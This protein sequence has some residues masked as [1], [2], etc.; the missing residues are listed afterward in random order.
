MSTS[1]GKKDF[2]K[3]G[4]LA[5]VLVDELDRRHGINPSH[6]RI[7]LE[8]ASKSKL[9]EL[10]R[11]EIEDMAVKTKLHSWSFYAKFTNE[12][13][14]SKDL[15][16]IPFY[17]SRTSDLILS[18][19]ELIQ[20]VDAN[21]NIESFYYIGSYLTKGEAVERNKVVNFTPSPINLLDL[22][23]IKYMAGV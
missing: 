6:S 14:K 2:G 11:K 23:H 12:C 15:F 1:L 17:K 7:A 10:G 16:K 5:I 18:D 9:L 19:T 4:L 13:I 3:V 20:E 8:L 21:G 22:N